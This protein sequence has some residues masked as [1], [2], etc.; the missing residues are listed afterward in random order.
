MLYSGEGL[1]VGQT[2][3]NCGE[4]EAVKKARRLKMD[5][6]IAFF[7]LTNKMTRVKDAHL[8]IFCLKKFFRF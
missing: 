5:F 3:E 6:K 1:G 2:Q 7:L 4:K 8:R